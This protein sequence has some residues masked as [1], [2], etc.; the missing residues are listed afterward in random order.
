MSQHEQSK[1][2]HREEPKEQQAFRGLA[3]GILLYFP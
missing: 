3:L 2:G 1:G